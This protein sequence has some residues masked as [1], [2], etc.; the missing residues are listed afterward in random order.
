MKILPVTLHLTH[1]KEFRIM[2][3]C[4]LTEIFI[5]QGD[6][7]QA[8]KK[9]EE[10]SGIGLGLVKHQSLNINDKNWQY[11]IKDYAWRTIE[12]LAE[13]YEDVETI[14]LNRDHFYE[15]LADVFHFFVELCLV[16]EL[17][18]GA[19]IDINPIGQDVLEFLFNLA[20]PEGSGDNARYKQHFQF[21]TTLGLA[22]EC[23]KNKPWKQKESPVD[24]PKFL[25]L[26]R[27]SMFELIS[28]YKLEGLTAD[29]LYE[30]YMRKAAIN[31]ERIRS[32]R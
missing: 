22:M 32:G 13:A 1:H 12:E 25:H 29:K 18:P 2:S 11:V 16:L 30:I 28:L 26:I 4:K 14:E 7:L 9:I 24:W 3:K 23:L 15:E 5:E 21:T 27:A 8:F 20:E 17:N 31:H 19:F 10:Q 6:L